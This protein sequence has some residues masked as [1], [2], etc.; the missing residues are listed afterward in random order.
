MIR[1]KRFL[2]LLLLFALLGCIILTTGCT[3]GEGPGTTTPVPT[4]PTFQPDILDKPIINAPPGEGGPSPFLFEFDTENASGFEAVGADRPGAPTLVLR[5]NASATLP[6]IVSSGADTEIRITRTD[7]LP[8]GVQVSYA[9]DS[10]T[11]EAGETTR[12]EMRL[13]SSEDLTVPAE[14]AVVVWMEG[15]GW[16]VGRVFYLGEV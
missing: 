11:L 9:P 10:F 1:E 8:Q 16:E 14:T 6:I 5:P 7:G 13:A 4:P 15:A 12:V 3:A 2:T